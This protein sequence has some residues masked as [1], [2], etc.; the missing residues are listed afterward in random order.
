MRI[1]TSLICVMVFTTSPRADDKAQKLPLAAERSVLAAVES[2]GKAREAYLD[3]ARKEQEKLIG[4]LQEEVKKET[5]NGKTQEALALRRFIGQLKLVTLRRLAE[6]DPAKR[7]AI[8]EEQTMAT[9]IDAVL[10]ART[11]Y[12]AAVK[13]EQEKLVEVLEKESKEASEKGN[14]TRASAVKTSIET[15]RGDSFRDLVEA[16][17]RKR[18]SAAE[19]KETLLGTWQVELPQK[20]FKT[21]WTFQENGTVISSEGAQRGTWRLDV[22]RNR[23]LITWGGGR[24]ESLILPLDTELTLGESWHGKDVRVEAKKKDPLVD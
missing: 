13:T 15:F 14:L 4:V 1:A 12:H 11:I 16:E 20:K 10:K 17:V 7:P 24:A 19:T 21:E 9:A 22:P 8:C 2:S 18:P 3:S 6:M 23:I 5:K